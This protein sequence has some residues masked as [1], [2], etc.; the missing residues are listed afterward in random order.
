M[1]F[2]LE[3][4]KKI[5]NS[6]ES[7]SVNDGEIRKRIIKIR[8]T[9]DEEEQ[10]AEQFEADVSEY[11]VLI[12]SPSDEEDSVKERDPL[13]QDQ[14]S[15][16]N[17]VTKKRENVSPKS[18]KKIKRNDIAP[19]KSPRTQEKS[20]II[21][22]SPPT[23]KKSIT[24]KKQIVKKEEKENTE[25]TKEIQLILSYD[26]IDDYNSEGSTFKIFD[27]E[28]GNEI[29]MEQS[30]TE[31]EEYTIEIQ[32]EQEV[33]TSKG[34]TVVKSHKCPFC[35]KFFRSKTALEGHHRTHTGNFS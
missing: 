21:E 20:P 11:E 31:T 35:S 19:R 10:N 34:K 14:I 9:T 29:I 6:C 17:S 2:A 28:N 25:D 12:T 24:D 23:K 3:F 18:N 22:K 16:T 7:R 30:T 26:M 13:T 15:K 5:E 27:G 33:T 1:K 4:K 8:S 32:K